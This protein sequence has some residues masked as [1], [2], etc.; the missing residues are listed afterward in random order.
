[1]TIATALPRNQVIIDMY[2]AGASY[3][4][5]AR[6]FQHGERR[7]RAMICKY[8]PELMRTRCEQASLAAKMNPAIRAFC[9]EDLG[10]IE[11]GPCAA[12]GIELVGR[13]QTKEL[14]TCGL[15]MAARA[16]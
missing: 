11:I 6:E 7:I 15:C 10:L 8:A 1:M 2:A 12:C 4:T 13:R 3:K 9:P 14:Q 16:A 5:L